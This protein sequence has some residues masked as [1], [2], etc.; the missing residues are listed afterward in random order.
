MIGHTLTM[1]L[2]FQHKRGLEML[3]YLVRRLTL[4]LLKLHIVIVFPNHFHIVHLVALLLRQVH[5]KVHRLQ[6][7]CRLV[8]Q[9]LVQPVDR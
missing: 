7:V 2:I 1:L 8:N 5:I 4:Q 6:L 3:Y 9:F